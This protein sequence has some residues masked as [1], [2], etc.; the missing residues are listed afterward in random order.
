[1]VWSMPAEVG[2]EED[3]LKPSK[4]SSKMDCC[5]DAYD[6]LL[7][8]PPLDAMSKYLLQWSDLLLSALE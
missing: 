8:C 6:L 2:L 7:A 1:M 4:G 5:L 3:V